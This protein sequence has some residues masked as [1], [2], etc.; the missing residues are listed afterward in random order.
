[1]ARAR[2]A[3]MARKAF[4]TVS[5]MRGRASNVRVGFNGAVDLL[6]VSIDVIVVVSIARIERRRE[7]QRT[8]KK[9]D[10]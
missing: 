2:A 3:V 8:T 9:P 4:G 7:A 6:A 5:A 1:M 10:S